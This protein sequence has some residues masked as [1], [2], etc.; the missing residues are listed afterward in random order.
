MSVYTKITRQD[1]EQIAQCYG[2]SPITDCSGIDD[3]ITNTIYK[4]QTKA[5]AYILTIFEELSAQEL[6]FY[7]DLMHYLASHDYPCPEVCKTQ[8]DEAIIMI[9]GK[10][11]IVMTFLPGSTP[12][13]TTV[14]QCKAVGVALA[15]LHMLSRDFDQSQANSRDITWMRA[16]SEKVR[17]F[18]SNSETELLDKELQYLA[19]HPLDDLPSGIIHADLFPDNVLFA[20]DKLTGVLDFY[21]ACSG[22]LIYDVAIT[23]Q[24]WAFD[25]PAKQAAL[26]EGYQSVR[27]LSSTESNALPQALH[28]AAMRFW[29]SRLH[30][31]HL[32]TEGES[33]L[34]KDPDHYKTILL[35]L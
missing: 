1:C 7:C 10:P 32:P 34:I 28:F 29:L 17:S 6:P 16:T 25:N 30:D 14:T 35:G 12:T 20:G 3:G 18:L 23:L 27:P 21:Y 24:A 26:L 11:A 13:K 19:S 8:D 15:K 4:L 2:L 5:S 22:V 33:V 9:A 31:F